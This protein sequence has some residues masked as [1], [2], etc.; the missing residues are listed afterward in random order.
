V[1]F[2]G[3]LEHIRGNLGDVP[4]DSGYLWVRCGYY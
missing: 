2:D 4:D 1:D 3:L